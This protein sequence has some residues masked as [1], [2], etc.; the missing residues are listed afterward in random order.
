MAITPNTEG[1]EVTKYSA[2]RYAHV[3]LANADGLRRRVYVKIQ[4]EGK[5]LHVGM[6]VTRDGDCWESRDGDREIIVWHDDDELTRRDM[7]LDMHYGTLV[8]A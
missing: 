8:A 6:R 4:S 1:S 2:G 7:R 5:G 3:A